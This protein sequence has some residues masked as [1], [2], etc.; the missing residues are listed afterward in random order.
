M[1][2]N[3]S[4]AVKSKY[5]QE[6]KKWYEFLFMQIEQK[7]TERQPFLL[8]CRLSCYPIFKTPCPRIKSF[9]KNLIMNSQSSTNKENA[10]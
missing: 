10:V 7:H 4:S 8:V 2:F 1:H 5:F 6:I 9:E 3:F